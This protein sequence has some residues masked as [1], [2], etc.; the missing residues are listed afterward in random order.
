M[1]T[2]TQAQT[3]E[4]PELK[5]HKS[6]P[7][8]DK[9][10]ARTIFNSPLGHVEYYANFIERSEATR[11]RD[12]LIKDVPWEKE[13]IVIFGKKITAPRLGKFFH[14]SSPIR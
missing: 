6:S 10:K 2:D 7:E 11:I 14:F 1:T 8:K 3:K 13:E 5:K 9:P 12:A 4:E